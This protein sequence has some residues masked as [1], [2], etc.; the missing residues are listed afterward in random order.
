MLRKKQGLLKTTEGV[1]GGVLS[2]F[3]ILPQVPGMPFQPE[4]VVASCGIVYMADSMI[5]H[6]NLGSVVK[7]VTACQAENLFRNLAIL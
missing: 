5:R 1:R 2:L 3:A 4:S 7:L 6:D